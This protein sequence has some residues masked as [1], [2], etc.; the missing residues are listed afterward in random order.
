MSVGL[1]VRPVTTTRDWSEFLEFRHRLYRPYSAFTRPLNRME[2]SL[3]DPR[4]HPFYEHAD[5]AGFL[6][7]RGNQIVG[8]IAAGDGLHAGDGGEGLPDMFVE[9]HGVA[10][11]FRHRDRRAQRH[12]RHGVTCAPALIRS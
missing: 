10:K 6:C 11:L 2:R 3:V 12:I 5:R 1:T 9:T 8:R 4:I 7:Y